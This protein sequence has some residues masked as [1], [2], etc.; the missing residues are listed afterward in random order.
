MK[1]LWILAY[2][3]FIKKHFSS[4]DNLGK[5]L[6]KQEV[7]LSKLLFAKFH[8]NFHSIQIGWQHNLSDSE[9]L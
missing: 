1:V 5:S 8:P 2:I 6:I 4:T 7:D 9:L 3:A